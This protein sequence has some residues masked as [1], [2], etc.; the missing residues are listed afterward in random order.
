MAAFDPKAWD[1]ATARLPPSHRDEFRLLG[2]QLAAYQGRWGLFI[3]GYD[4][5]LVRAR[6]AVEIAEA[7]PDGGWVEID[8]DQQPDWTDLKNTLI[9]ESA[10]KPYLQIQRLEY[11]LD[12]LA[13]DSTGQRLRSMNRGRDGFALAVNVP[14][15]LWLRPAQITDLAN[16]A[17]DLW[18]WRAG[19]YQFLDD[20]A[21]RNPDLPTRPNIRL[22]ERSNRPLAQRQERIAQLQSYL[23]DTEHQIG[24]HL[25]LELYTELSV[26]I[27][28][29]GGW[30]ESENI[31]RKAII[32]ISKIINQPYSIFYGLYMLSTYLYF[33]GKFDEALS[34]LQHEA[35]ALCD[36]DKSE[37]G[38][39]LVL[40]LIA[41]ILTDQGKLDD[42]LRIHQ[43]ELLPIQERRGDIRGK[44][45]TL[46]KS[47]DILLRQGK[48][49]E[50]LH[51][52]QRDALPLCEHLGDVSLQATVWG[53]IATVL[54][55]Q[56]NFDEALRIAKQEELSRYSLL[57]DIR[58]EASSKATMAT[59]L[60]ARGQTADAVHILQTDV[61]PVLEEFGD[62]G[63][64]EAAKK[65]LT[66]AQKSSGPP[67]R[68]A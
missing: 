58:G 2:R 16:Q 64:L 29:T 17:P 3:L 22:A 45:I 8:E 37:S 38:K 13:Q 46:G 20:P 21:H 18:S 14:V 41:D 51:C 53:Q 65:L 6:I 52:L 39:G 49:D 11:W 12:P 50:A 35:L 25:K 34:I 42:A 30:K 48:S 63:N 26:L 43:Q 54:L 60:F 5:A 23:A 10:G 55:Y 36:H 47:A 59:I 67:S 31:C 27:S 28:S 4:H 44:I 62:R 1:A 32:P 19:L 24:E 66:L 9:D 33:Q 57:G 68:Q 56:N 61:V 15:L 7:W 40:E